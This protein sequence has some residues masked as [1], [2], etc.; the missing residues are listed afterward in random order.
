MCRSIRSAPVPRR[1]P[2]RSRALVG[3]RRRSFAGR[4][5][6]VVLPQRTT[7]SYGG[8]RTTVI[9]PAGGTTATTITDARGRTTARVRRNDLL[10][11]PGRQDRRGDRPGE[12]RLAIHL[13][14]ARTSDRR[15]RSR[16]G[17]HDHDV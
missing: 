12:E 14:P 6:A 11:Y 17:P 15:G 8:D 5:R 10:L 1:R 13:R 4:R 3:R 9:P 2:P 7:T 16:Q